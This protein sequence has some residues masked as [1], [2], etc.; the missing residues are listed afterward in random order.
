ME[1]LSYRSR[2]IIETPQDIEERKREERRKQTEYDQQQGLKRGIGLPGPKIDGVTHVFDDGTLR[3]KKLEK[4]R[5]EQSAHDFAAGS[6][7]N[8]KRIGW[9]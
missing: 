8:L 4:E 3:S 9:V 7:L 5:E 1:D 2:E 6:R